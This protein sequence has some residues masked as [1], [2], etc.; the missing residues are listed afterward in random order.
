MKLK[1]LGFVFLYLL[2]FVSSGLKLNHAKAN[3]I[4]Q[5]DLEIAE[6]KVKL[7]NSMR[8]MAYLATG[9]ADYITD[10]GV[11]PK[12]AGIYD[13][14]S[15]FHKALVDFYLK[16]VPIKDEWG[17]NIRVYCGETCNGIYN[18]ISGC[19]ADDFVIVSYGL[20]E[21]K[22]DWEYN[23]QN[24]EAGFYVLETLKDFDKDIVNWNG[25]WIR[26]PHRSE[27]R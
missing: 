19:G 17:N 2:L 7:K 21:K 1:F 24:R 14:N 9:I 12:Q 11:A 4:I 13:E 8:N 22:E 15:E 23:R 16:I 18:G 27:I 6:Q 3:A 5:E 26:S 20:D 25:A 10:F